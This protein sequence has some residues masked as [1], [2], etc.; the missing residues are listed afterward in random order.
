[1]AIEV[2]DRVYRLGADLVNWFIVEDAGKFTIIDAGNPNQYDQLPVAM[3]DLGHAM[4]NIEAIVLTHAHGD[5]LGSSSR[6]KK[7]SEATVHV[8]HDD[9]ALAKGDAHREYERH[10]VRD[11]HH[12]FSW[13]SLAFFMRGGA[14]KAPPVHELVEFGHGEVLDLPGRP[15]VIAT[16]GHTDGSSCLELTDRK[17]LFTGDS[18]VTLNIVTG[19]RTPR[20]MPG[21][22]NKDSQ[23][24][25]DSLNE[26]K[27][28]TA[29]VILPG[30]GEPLSGP[31]PDAVAT[32]QKTG[33]S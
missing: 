18:L 29:D 21:S 13:K 5:H 12:P 16:P 33:A 11:L 28:S 31:V 19:D 20:I 30:H 9:V 4:E 2:A 26:L 10:F 24:S 8:H 1:M 15:R 14:M 27:S 6:I 7:D 3:A 23:R 32:A 22:F 17:V 25:L